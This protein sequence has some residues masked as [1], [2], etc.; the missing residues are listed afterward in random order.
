LVVRDVAPTELEQ[1][2]HAQTGTRLGEGLNAAGALQPEAMERTLA[3]VT[4]FAER[5]RAHEADLSCIAT[6][7]VR[8]ATNAAAFAE[9]VRA[10]SGAALEVL[11]GS[12]EARA[13][14]VGATYGAPHDGR[15]I[16]VVDIG[17]GSTECAA[18]R[19]GV[20]ERGV[21]VEIGSV[22]VS[23]RFPA[24]MGSAPGPVARAAAHDAREAIDAEIA[25]FSS[26]RPVEV[27][28][29][30]AGT[31]LTVAAVAFGS[32]VDRLRGAILS[33]AALE[34]TIDRL[35]DATLEERRAMPGMLP[36]RADILAGG[37]LI[38][39]QTLHAL[40]ASEACLESNDLLLG[41]LI[42][43]GAATRAE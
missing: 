36:Q 14:F 40:G 9:R 32:H 38:L 25:V 20:L 8:R 39:A 1:L 16:A 23:E 13:S 33:A 27:V 37:A 5:A 28:R 41:H 6:S 42:A 17:G 34:A 21:S 29:C 43:R 30:V 11:D 31:A 19:D 2:E 4:A 26:L 22:R 12:A 15:R 18:G 3:A 24:L 10:L 35:L 7:A